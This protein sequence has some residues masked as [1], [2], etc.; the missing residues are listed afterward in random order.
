MV[1]SLYYL[2]IL[3]AISNQKYPSFQ[4]LSYFAVVVSQEVAPPNS[5]SCFIKTSW[6]LCF[7]PITTKQSMVCANNSIYY[8]LKIVF[9]FALYAISLYHYADSFKNHQPHD[10]SV[11][12]ILSSVCLRWNH[13]VPYLNTTYGLCIFSPFSF[14]ECENYWYFTLSS[15]LYRKYESLANIIVLK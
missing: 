10:L 13:F 9:I 14:D 4:L 15:R 5:V 6:K 3:F 7:L 8:G 11:W 12:Y 1:S 2:S